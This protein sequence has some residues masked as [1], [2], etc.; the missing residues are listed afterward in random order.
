[1][2]Q[3]LHS[4]I[5]AAG[6]GTRMKS[7]LPKVLQILASKPLLGH[8]LDTAKSLDSKIHVVYGHGGGQVQAAFADADINWVLQAEQKGTWSW[9]FLV[10]YRL[11]VR[12]P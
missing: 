6:K 5:L 3:T 11:F 2:S 4:V 8:V 12:P 7:R 9:C 10:T 1:V